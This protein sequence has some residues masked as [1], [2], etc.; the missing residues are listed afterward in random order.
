[1]SQ[2]Q[3]VTW[4]CPEDG[5]STPRSC[6]RARRLTA[7]DDGS[8]LIV[9]IMHSVKN[10]KSMGFRPYYRTY[11]GVNGIPVPDGCVSS[12]ARGVQVA[13]PRQRTWRSCRS[14]QRVLRVIHAHGSSKTI[15]P[16]ILACPGRGARTRR[17]PPVTDTGRPSHRQPERGCAGVPR[18]SRHSRN[19][20]GVVTSNPAARLARRVSV[21][22]RRSGVPG[23]AGH[24]ESSPA[25]ADSEA[26]LLTLSQWSFSTCTVKCPTI[27]SNFACTWA[28]MCCSFASFFARTCSDPT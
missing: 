27:G 4:N 9:D 14:C 13:P 2:R 28:M 25:S 8:A 19:R 21:Y 1:V 15:N 16:E 22:R 24:P 26:E 20:A 3:A 18:V 6:P 10:H 23:P 5:Q 17:F 7:E 12:A 11:G